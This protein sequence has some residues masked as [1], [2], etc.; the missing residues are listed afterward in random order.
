MRYRV[1]MKVYATAWVEVEADDPEEAM[2]RAD[3][4]YAETG[5]SICHQCGHEMSDPTYG[6]PVEAMQL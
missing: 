4:E 2:R 3:D 5:I 6:D 1:A